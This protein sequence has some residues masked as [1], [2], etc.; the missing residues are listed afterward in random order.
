MNTVDF[1][2]QISLLYG[3]LSEFCTPHTCD[4]MSA[5][6]K[7]EYLWAD[8]QTKKPIKLSAPEYI[9]RLMS[10]VQAILDDEKMFPPRADVPFPKAFVPTI[11]QIFK[12]LFRV[13]AHVY[14]SHFQKVGQLGEEAHLNTCFKHFYYFIEEFALVDK[15]ETA[16]LQQ[17]IDNLTKQDVDAP[18]GP[19]LRKDKDNKDK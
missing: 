16:P 4:V 7:Y 12:R 11:K 10:W 1:Y 9:D 3:T 5:G 14:Y 17:L 8:E 6:P 13:Y 19:T 2:N 15:K 18:P